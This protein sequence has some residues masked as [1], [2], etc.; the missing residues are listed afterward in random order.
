M[1]AIPPSDLPEED[2]QTLSVQLGFAAPPDTFSRTMIWW[3]GRP[4]HFNGSGFARNEEHARALIRGLF[5]HSRRDWL[6]RLP[7]RLRTWAASEDNQRRFLTWLLA[8][9]ISL[10]AAE[11]VQLGLRPP[12]PS[13]AILTPPGV[14]LPDEVTAG[15]Q[16]GAAAPA[17]LQVE[18]PARPVRAESAP[19]LRPSTPPKDRTRPKTAR[20]KR[21]SAVP[22][23]AA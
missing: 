13:D 22:A 11:K 12:T 5:H 10:V 17:V 3:D 1:A 8:N 19:A 7:A 21:K 16:P 20:R 6:A 15:V 9:Q 14:K 2:L 18:P 4:V 23:A